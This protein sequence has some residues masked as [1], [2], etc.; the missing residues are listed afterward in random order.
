MQ[1]KKHSPIVW[2]QSGNFSDSG[3]N[4]HMDIKDNDCYWATETAEFQQ[5]KKNLS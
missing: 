4:S 1:K 2:E 5:R 3:F